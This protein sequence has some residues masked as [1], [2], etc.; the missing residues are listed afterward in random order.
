MGRAF[1]QPR[2]ARYLTIVNLS[3]RDDVRSPGTTNAFIVSV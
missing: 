1:W 2:A 3:G